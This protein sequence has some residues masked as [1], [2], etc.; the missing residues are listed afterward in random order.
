MV[1][2]IGDIA[3]KGAITITNQA[4]SDIIAKAIATT[5]A[6]SV[7][8]VSLTA[9]QIESLTQAAYNAAM[10]SIA[11]LV[12]GQTAFDGFRLGA[13]NPVTITDHEIASDGVVTQV[14]HTPG[15]TAANGVLTMDSSV[16]EINQST[17][18]GVLQ[19]GP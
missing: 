16:I 17:L 12:T 2:I 7:S 4:L 14:T 18:Q 8:N 15:F 11:E 1:N 6:S 3:A 13:T 19:D 10:E 5:G 9:A